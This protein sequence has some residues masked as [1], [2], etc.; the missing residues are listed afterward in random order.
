MIKGSLVDSKAISKE[1]FLKINWHDVLK[2]W[3]VV[4]DDIKHIRAIGNKDYMVN[5]ERLK[6][7]AEK[8]KNTSVEETEIWT[9]VI[10]R[11]QI[12][13]VHQPIISNTIC[14]VKAIF[15]IE[16][17]EKTIRDNVSLKN[18][19]GDNI[20]GDVSWNALTK[21]IIFQTTMTNVPMN[22]LFL[23]PLLLSD[24]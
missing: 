16:I 15:D 9:D 14:I 4:Y 6:S 22:K 10:I 5:F 3:K 11:P 23:L 20:P 2:C 17:D 12:I 24:K 1:E 8:F 7:H 18:Q 13:K 19:R 21:T